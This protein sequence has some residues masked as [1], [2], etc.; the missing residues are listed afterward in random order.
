LKEAALMNRAMKWC[1]GAAAVTLAA[2]SIVNGCKYT[3]EVAAQDGRALGAAAGLSLLGC[4]L[5]I[6]FVAGEALKEFE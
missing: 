1:F 6:G 5:I 2:A 4:V 3:K